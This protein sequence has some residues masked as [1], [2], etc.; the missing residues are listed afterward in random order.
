MAGA[1]GGDGG[2]DAAGGRAGASGG[3][4]ATGAPLRIAFVGQATYFR[5][6]VPTGAHPGLSTTF[7][8]H[9]QGTP[10]GPVRAKLEAF[11][12]DAVVVFRP[13][14]LEPGALA[15]LAAPVLGFLTEPI[16]R[17]AEGGDAA[18]P[19]LVKRARELARLDPRNVDRIVT[20]DP[21]TV[22]AADQVMPVW[23]SLPLPVAD[24]LFRP[25]TPLAQPPR[26]L[27]VGRST[28][29]REAFLRAA[30]ERFDLLHVAFGAGV[31]DLERLLDEHQVGINLHNEPYPSFENRV[32]LHLAAAHLVISE[33]LSPTHG[34]EPGI[35]HLEV[36]S[37]QELVDALERVADRPGDHEPIRARGRQQ[38]E[39]YRASTVFPRLA[40]DLLRDVAVFG[41]HREAAA[42]RLSRAAA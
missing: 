15:D 24:R 38:A 5:A 36:G 8:E 1:S 12:P 22:P 23:R 40:R 27:F 6:C 37:P 42:H 31:D 13:E 33:P 17:R 32:C 16:P 4:D 34:L 2:A 26:S 35:D 28:P 14:V 41:T 39:R 9:R 20:F 7:V 29:H 30:E 18:H 19:D 11:A 25:R 3:G 21:L 10:A